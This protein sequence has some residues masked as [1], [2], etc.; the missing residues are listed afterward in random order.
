MNLTI[1]LLST[2]FI[3]VVSLVIVICGIWSEGKF[4]E[5]KAIKRRLLFLS[6]GGKH[7]QEKLTHY[8]NLALR[9]VGIFEQLIMKIP[10]ISSLDRMLVKS[11]LP[12]NATSVVLAT[13][14]LGL[15]GFVAGYR[16]LPKLGDAAALGL[17]LM[18]VP[19]VYLKL[20]ERAYYAK[21]KEQLPEALDLLGRAMRSGHAL[22]SGLDMIA[23]EME[24][25]VKSEF[26]A[27]VDEIKLGLTVQD[28]L[29]NLCARV[30]DTD[31]RFF[32]IAI[33]VQKETGGNLAEIL[34]NISRLIRERVQ[35]DRQLKAL[36]AEGRLSAWVLIALPLAMFV[37]IYFVNYEYLSLLWTEKVGLILLI[38]GIVLQVV[39]AYVMKRIVAIEI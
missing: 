26:S 6:A 21:F 8:R 34:D 36:T 16:F 2:V 18:T 7:G 1:M 33:T 22:T 19:Y 28:A 4:A 39:G 20:T 30:P 38:G 15:L 24:D 23:Q 9:N 10:R 11:K 17:V 3:F 29:D 37:Y 27:T 25:P 31:L 12:I 35:F 14:T 5:K 13:L 32:A